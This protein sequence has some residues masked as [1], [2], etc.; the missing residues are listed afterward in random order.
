MQIETTT[1]EGLL[2]LKPVLYTDERGA[3]MESFRQ[4]V[5]DAATPQCKPFVQDNIAI[6][7]KKGTLRGLHFQRPPHAQA[8]LVSVNRGAIFDV[9]VDLRRKSPTY[10]QW[11]SFL[12]SA[13]S[14]IRLLVPA[15]FAHGYMTLEDNTE[16]FYKVDDYYAPDCD[17]G[18]PWNDPDLAV[19]WPSGSMI[20]SDRDKKWAPFKGFAS[21]F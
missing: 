16:V 14:H 4:D 9:A 19:D 10:G 12:L 2:I 1:L 5:M 7:L 21:P 17:G 8:K 6:S 15:G 11:Q 13:L 3:F 20:F 18:L